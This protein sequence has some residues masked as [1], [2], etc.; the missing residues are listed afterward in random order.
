[1]AESEIK[2]DREC[3]D[4]P[5]LTTAKLTDEQLFDAEGRPHPQVLADHFVS[6][7][8]LTE[9]QTMQILNRA[10]AMLKEEPNLIR[11]KAPVVIVGDIHG[12]FYDLLKMFEVAGSMPPNSRFLF[13]GDYVD[14]GYFSVECFLYLLALK[15]HHPDH[16]I[17]L[18]GNHECRHLTRHFTFRLECVYKYSESLYDSCMAAFDA[19]PIAAV[20][21]DQLF[22][23]HG[24]ISPDLHTLEDVNSF[25]RFSDPPKSG[26]FCDLLWSDPDPNYGSESLLTPVF[27]PNTVRGCSYRF[28]YKAVNRF[29]TNNNLLAVVRGHEAQDNGYRLYDNGRPGAFPSVITLFSAPNYC[30]AYNNKGA[31]IKYDNEVLNIRQFKEVPHPYYLPKFMNAFDWSLPFLGEKVSELL[32]AVL[33]IPT[34]ESSV[35]GLTSAEREKLELENEEIERVMKEKV[36]A[37]GKMGQMYSNLRAERESLTELENTVGL[38]TLPSEELVVGDDIIRNAINTFEEAKESDIT[39]ERLPDRGTLSIS[40]IPDAVIEFPSPK[41]AA[42]TDDEI[43]SEISNVQ[44]KSTTGP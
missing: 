26:L 16:V 23:V 1:M 38:Q 21:S 11:M 27:P 29:L 14:R 15:I 30:D 44:E 34:L 2:L 18:R 13:L 42:I 3:P 32:M 8:R 9:A 40:P 22:C 39:N 7:G 41:L 4:V 17:M 20:V 28:T 24:G 6:E 36:L 25:H 37:L 12:Q 5:P 19:L 43:V 31:I 35:E 33:Q 10:T